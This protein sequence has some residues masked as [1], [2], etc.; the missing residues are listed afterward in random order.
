[1]D[2]RLKQIVLE[3][4]ESKK[5]QKFFFA[6]CNDDSLSKKEKK[7]WKQLKNEKRNTNLRNQYLYVHT[8]K[9]N[10]FLWDG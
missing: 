5:Q 2:Q 6:K 10:F 4:F 1:M 7:K 3:K 9:R 8:R